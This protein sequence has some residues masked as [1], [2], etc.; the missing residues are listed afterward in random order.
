MKILHIS[1][2]D[3]LGGAARASYRLHRALLASGLNSEM[4]VRIKK[5]DDWTILSSTS[6]VEKLVDIF[7]STI[8]SS[9]NKLQKSKNIS[10]HSGNWLPSFWAKKINA[11]DADIVNIHWVGNETL[12]I[13]D[14][15]KINKPIV[16]TMHDMWP[17]CGSEH[18]ADYGQEARWKIGYTPRNRASND[19][20]IDLDRLT[21]LRKKNAWNNQLIHVVAPSQWMSECIKDSILFKKN[22]TYII[23][24]VLDTRVY[25]PLNQDFCRDALNL[26]KDKFIILFGAIGGSN[27]VN[28]GHDLL[29]SALSKATNRIYNDDILCI[30][31]GQSEPQHPQ[32]IPFKTKWL[33][34]I[35]DDTTLS[36]LYNSANVMVVPS[37][38]DNLP[39]TATEAHACG[40][41][42]VSFATTGLVDIIEHKKT[43]Y[44]AK[45]FCIDDLANG[46]IWI[47][48]N[49]LY[50]SDI[51]DNVRKKA[52]KLWASDVVIEKYIDVYKKALD[53]YKK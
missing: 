41:P 15:G 8:G 6:R 12:S 44:L 53:T 37:R 7:R 2:S 17:F 21:W 5:T 50:Q 20:G 18:I 28:K 3:I 9:I 47:L 36:L 32:K 35:Y 33:G 29:I 48:A 26:P 1:H 13:K 22:P 52:E 4:M 14:L 46:I 42:V 23:P 11:S 43:G 25:K 27:D 30:I 10:L 45:P 34:H 24:N 16:W 31:F 19:H 39:Q 51:R 38:I 40:T 49:K